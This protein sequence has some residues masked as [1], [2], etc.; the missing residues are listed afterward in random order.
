MQATILAPT[1]HL[2]WI[3][4]SSP[5]SATPERPPQQLLQAPIGAARLLLQ[6]SRFVL[7]CGARGASTWHVP[8]ARTR[9]SGSTKTELTYFRSPGWAGSCPLLVPCLIVRAPVL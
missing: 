6:V 3:S 9:L 5:S 8:R 1:P 7:A 4:A 2:V